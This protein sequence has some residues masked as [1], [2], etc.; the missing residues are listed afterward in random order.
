M[1]YIFLLIFGICITILGIFN[2]KGNIST[3]HWYNRLKTAKENT[4]KYGR[5]MVYYSCWYCA[6]V[7][8]YDLR[9]NKI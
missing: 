4:K 2:L 3:I 7:N 1:E 6:G 5:T 9:S 8:F